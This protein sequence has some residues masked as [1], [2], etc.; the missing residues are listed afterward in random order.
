MR[1][2]GQPK[3]T[4][5][6]WTVTLRRSIEMEAVVTVQADNDELAAEIA[7]K[8]VSDPRYQGWQYRKTT[9]QVHSCNEQA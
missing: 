7:D 5:P 3:A 8:Q 6:K 4:G 9:I 2:D 1:N